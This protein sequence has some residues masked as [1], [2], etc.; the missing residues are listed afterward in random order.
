MVTEG[1]SK[2]HVKAMVLEKVVPGKEYKLDLRKLYQKKRG[3]HEEELKVPV[4]K[5]K[6]EA[7][8]RNHILFRGK[9]GFLESFTYS[10]L[11]RIFFTVETPGR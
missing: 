11:F 1:F 2:G 10:D 4:K 6:C 5:M 8:Y 3:K 9:N 7:I